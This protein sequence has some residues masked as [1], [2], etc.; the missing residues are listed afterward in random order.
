MAKGHQRIDQPSL[1]LHRVIAGALRRD[2]SLL[3]V[4]RA[5]LERWSQLDGHSQPYWD[6][7]RELLNCPELRG[8]NEGPRYDKLRRSRVS[9][10][11]GLGALGDLCAFRTEQH[12]DHKTRAQLEYIIR[13]AVVIADSLDMIV[14]GSQAALG[15][16]P[17]APRELLVS[18]AGDSAGDGG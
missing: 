15:Q 5:N 1:A 3:Q 9:F 7:W 18:D 17:D 14:I 13:A 2:P 11:L 4:A 10:S 8:T 16:F 6:T 12:S